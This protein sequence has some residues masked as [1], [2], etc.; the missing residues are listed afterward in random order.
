MDLGTTVIPG[1]EQMPSEWELIE[2]AKA[3]DKTALGDLVSDCWQPLY[4]FV[5]YKL[6]STDEAQ[7][8]TQETFFRAFRSLSSYQKTDSRFGT[9]LGRIA[10][11]L[12]TDL[13]RKKGRTPVIQDISNQQELLSGG[14]NPV[15]TLVTL[16]T[17]ET[18]AVLL[19]ELPLE[20][21]QVIEYRI[22]AGLPVKEVANAMDKSEAAVKMLQQRALKN[23]R[24]KLLAKGGWTDK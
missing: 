12:I 1:G 8:I 24:E 10:N 17:K 14:E 11:N 3:G 7:D 13:W 16:E 23:M 2:K 20:Q 18:L 4:R 19:A 6:G 15:E 22:L 5:S 21:R 9:Y